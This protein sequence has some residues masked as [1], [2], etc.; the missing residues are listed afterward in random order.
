MMTRVEAANLDGDRYPDVVTSHQFGVEI[1]YG[2]G[3]T[4]A[5]PVTLLD[6]QGYRWQLADVDADARPDFVVTHH[7]E[8][9]SVTFLL[10]NLGSRRFGAPETI[11]RTA[12]AEVQAVL[13][14]TGDGSPDLLIPRGELPALLAVNDGRGQFTVRETAPVPQAVRAAGDLD[15]D[16]D[17]DLVLHAEG[18][19][20]TI[21]RSN[22]NGGFA[23]PETRTFPTTMTPALADLD[24]DGR[25]DLLALLGWG[26]IEI[27]P[28][29]G[30]QPASKIAY[31][32]TPRD[33]VTADFNGDGAVDVAIYSQSSTEPDPVVTSVPRLLV[34]L[35][36]GRGGFVRAPDVLT[37][38]QYVLP[39][40]VDTAD[41]DR[42][43]TVDMV[44]PGSDTSVA[45]VF[46]NGDGTFDTARYIQTSPGHLW[47]V[48]ADLDG[49][50][51]DELITRAVTFA[52]QYSTTRLSIGWLTPDGT[53]AFE[54]L[55]AY[56]SSSG[57]GVL[58]AAG[59]RTIVT[60]AAER[61]R[62]YSRTAPGTW[63]EVVS[64]P[65]GKTLAVGAGDVT[66]DG[67]DELMAVVSEA[68]AAVL[69]VYDA[70]GNTL[71]SLEV[72]PNWHPYGIVVAELTGD[73]KNDLLVL[74]EGSFVLH[75]RQPL[76]GYL[77]L[78]PGR[79]DGTF[80]APRRLL[81][82]T[83]PGRTPLLGDYNGDGRT[84]I[85]SAQWLLLGD[86]RGNFAVS[87]LPFSAHLAADVNRDGITDVVSGLTLWQGT[88][89][90]VF[91]GRGTYMF[92]FRL[93]GP[94]IVR[95][96][97]DGPPSLLGIAD[98]AGE[99]LVADFTCAAARRRTARP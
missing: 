40:T 66:G 32:G 43:G 62:V 71:H 20:A 77:A 81:D 61:L 49:D 33:V 46:G 56:P 25:S 1:S 85:A 11:A 23:A 36:D 41:F 39:G 73:G 19:R 47:P 42:D 54:S 98:L 30:V 91:I 76:D 17:G 57:D 93:Q 14:F 3:N 67:R 26:Q 96:T 16:G 79:G 29:A 68:A 82:E 9:E 38:S 52:G 92:P 53:Y 83:R 97:P 37:G 75:A 35:S 84:D 31:A 28:G 2:R 72:G 13:D 48:A 18:P 60:A 95:R 5:P 15:G 63:V 8:Q 51:I 34:Y 69:R 44:V 89:T 64:L 86:G 90:G 58:A 88:R 6:G 94:V 74:R 45:L 87:E 12:R 7:A 4:L 99:F 78:L 55:P 65:V 24:S 50:G 80:D 59:T 70:G 10:R 27:Y 22:G 21:L